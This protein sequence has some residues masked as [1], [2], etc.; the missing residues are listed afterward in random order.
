MIDVMGTYTTLLTQATA[1]LLRGMSGPDRDPL[2]D[3]LRTE[4]L[5]KDRPR[6]RVK[7]VGKEYVAIPLSAGWTA[8]GRE[9]TESQLS[10]FAGGRGHDSV[11]FLLVDLVSNAQGWP[12]SESQ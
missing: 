7:H 1:A 6:M 12:T 8:V 10:A 2:V 5:Q 3:S 4:L 9:L 11:G